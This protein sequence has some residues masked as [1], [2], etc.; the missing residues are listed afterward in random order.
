MGH[1]TQAKKL[2][3]IEKQFISSLEDCFSE[4][5]KLKSTERC[6]TGCD[7]AGEDSLRIHLLSVSRETA[8]RG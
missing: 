3:E 2:L 5:P 1:I 4:S 8:D 6:P 7:H